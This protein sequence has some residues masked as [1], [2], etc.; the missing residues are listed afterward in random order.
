MFLSNRKKEEN[1]DS[2]CRENLRLFFISKQPSMMKQ[3]IAL[4]CFGG[5]SLLR[6]MGR[7]FI[8]FTKAD[9]AFYSFT[10]KG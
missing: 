8:T 7:S 6:E 5:S 2:S 4:L 9:N 1:G 3:P 10:L